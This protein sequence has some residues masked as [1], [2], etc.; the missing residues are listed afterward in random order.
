[1]VRLA[2]VAALTL[3]AC[4]TTTDDRPL[5]LPYITETILAPTCG[6]AECH[7]TFR[8]AVGDVF[9]TVSGARKSIVNNGLVVIPDDQAM[10][11]GSRLVQAITVGLPSIL[12]PG[13]GKIRMPYDAPMPNEDVRLI[14]KWIAAGA[15]GAQ[16]VPE[17]G[18]ACVGQNVVACGSDGNLGATLMVCT[19]TCSQGACLP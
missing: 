18:N 15:K 5:T 19:T 12:S 10:P 14:E 7:S 6:S 3:A 11:A 1:M 4:G 13:S 9:D 8:Q 16:C 17:E 2:V